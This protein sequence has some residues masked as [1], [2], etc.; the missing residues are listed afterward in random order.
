MDT[1]TLLDRDAIARAAEAHGV[2]RLRVFGSVLTDR[3]D[4]ATSDVDFLVDFKP[5][6][7][8]LLGEYFGLRDDLM[9]IVGRDV[10]LVMADA[11]R[12]PYFKASAFSVAQDIYAA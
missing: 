11:V 9:K 8:D 2:Q 1:Q 7:L 5:D 12:N 6:T 4:P 10:D 3:F